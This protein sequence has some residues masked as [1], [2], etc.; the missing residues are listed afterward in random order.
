MKK[1]KRR[2]IK[3]VKP[4]N[5]KD[6]DKYERWKESIRVD[7]KQAREDGYRVIYLDETLVTK[8][9]IRRFEYCNPGEN[10][11]IT[12]TDLGEPVVGI[13]LAVSYEKGLEYSEI[14]DFSVNTDKF[15]DYI[16]NLYERNRKDKLLLYMDNLGG[17]VANLTKQKMSEYG[18]RFVYNVPYQPDLN[19]VESV[20]SILKN[21]IKRERTAN[22]V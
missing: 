1:I 18:M 16:D 8:S 20:I 6:T 12:Q 14:F 7:L 5:A 15:Q 11:E 22:M 10:P 9:T 2:R 3:I 17:H 4:F 13:I 21:T 19:A